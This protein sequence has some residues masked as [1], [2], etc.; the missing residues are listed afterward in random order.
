MLERNAAIVLQARMGSTRLP[1]KV[2]ADLAGRSI[3]EH[4]VE[5][6]RATSGLPVVL[7]TTT[8][9]ED[10]CLEQL[11]ERL[12]ITVLRGS[13]V[14]VLGRFA[15]VVSTLRLSALI[16]ATAD[17]PA[18][19]LDAPRRTLDQLIRTGA[20]HVVECGLPYGAAV[21]AVAAD[22]L[23]RAADLAIDGYDREHVT[24]LLRR[25]RRFIALEAV[26]PP[27]LTRPS[28]RLTVD[29][30]QDLHFMRRLFA[31]AGADTARALPLEQLIDAA[32]RL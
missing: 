1:G 22:A 24:P 27:R 4:C 3:L 20:D 32:G 17:N 31:A 25:D 13:D 11:G 6:L 28:L 21:E 12:G 23:L 5:R 26:A 2:L 10:D 7:A 15:L 14:D 8:L 19:D 18:V 16:R 9:P 30:E 29:T